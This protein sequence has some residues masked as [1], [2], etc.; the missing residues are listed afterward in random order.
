MTPT[1]ILVP[2]DFSDTSINA[3]DYAVALAA[4][5]GA[6]IHLVH[7]I[8]MPTLGLPELGLAWASVAMPEAVVVAQ[9]KLDAV[10]A[11]RE[12]L[13]QFGERAISTGDVRDDILEAAERVKADLIVIGTHG[14]RGMSR[15]ILG[16]T[17]EAVVRTAPCPVLTVRTQGKAS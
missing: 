9:T 10:V 13:A 14:R 17:A 11:A 2:I 8:G 12:G 6:R 7:A 5:L 4:K 1:N 3:L 16:S 15:A